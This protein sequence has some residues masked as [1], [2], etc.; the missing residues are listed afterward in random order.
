MS[1]TY[2]TLLC[3]LY[4]G[5][6]V[7]VL[8]VQVFRWWKSIQNHRL[9]SF[10]LTTHHHIAPGTLTGPD[11]A[12]LQHLLQVV[13]NLLNQCWGICLNHSLKGVS[14]VTFIMCSIGWVQP[15]SAGSNKNMSWYSARSQQA[16]STSLGDQESNPLK[17]SSL[18]SLPCLCLA[19]NLGV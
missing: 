1:S 7:V 12:Q 6:G 4:S 16:A 2:Q 14:S 18:N 15:N 19:V 8:F 9:P 3:L 10:F 11:S 13:H 5:Q 17:S